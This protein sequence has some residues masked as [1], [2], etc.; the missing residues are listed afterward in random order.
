MLP[1]HNNLLATWISIHHLCF[2]LVVTGTE[3]GSELE[4]VIGGLELETVSLELEPI[5]HQACTNERRFPWTR[6]LIK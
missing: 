1:V 5:G 4:I 6:A 3:T 2:S